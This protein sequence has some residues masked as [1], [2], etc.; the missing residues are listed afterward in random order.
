MT[1]PERLQD[2]PKSD[3]GR[4]LSGL[5]SPEPSPGAAT[6]SWRALQGRLAPSRGVRAGWFLAGATLATLVTLVVVRPFAR[7]AP[8]FVVVRDGARVD[9]RSVALDVPGRLEVTSNATPVEVRTG[10]ETWP[11]WSRSATGRS[12]GASS[13]ALIQPRS[14]PAAADGA[15]ENWRA[16]SGNAR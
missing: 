5:P 7:E 9:S 8:G 10:S 1:Q 3:V 13:L 16:T 6:R 11:G 4:L 2:D 12:S 15:C 14:P